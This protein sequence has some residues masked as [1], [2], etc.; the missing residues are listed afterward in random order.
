MCQVVSD[1]QNWCSISSNVNISFQ[2]G[3][4]EADC[5]IWLFCRAKKWNDICQGCWIF[6]VPAYLQNVQKCGTYLRIW[7]ESRRITICTL[8]N[9]L[10]SLRFMPTNFDT[11]LN[12]WWIVSKFLP[13]LL[14]DEQKQLELHQCLPGHSEVISDFHTSFRRSL[15]MT[16]RDLPA[17]NR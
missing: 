7:H 10:G 15:Q 5:S 4:S 11:R 2:R 6:R 8:A 14:I 16:I 12:F 13:C 3:S 1:W 9:E 17:W